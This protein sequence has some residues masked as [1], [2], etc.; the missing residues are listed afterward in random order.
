MSTRAALRCS[1]DGLRIA[2][3][4]EPESGRR[5]RLLSQ[6]YPQI[7]NASRPRWRGPYMTFTEVLGNLLG[8]WVWPVA[9]VMAII[10][11]AISVISWAL[12]RNK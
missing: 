3:D 10:G 1:G 8:P 2:P 7:T 11:A 4:Y 12:N 5:D 9:I 6:P